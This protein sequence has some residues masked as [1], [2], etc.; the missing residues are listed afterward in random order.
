[1]VSNSEKN[2]EQAKRKLVEGFA[3]GM[4]HDLNNI[5]SAI[6]GYT[7]LCLLSEDI[8]HSIRSNLQHLREA[9]RTA[10]EFSNLIRIIG[11]RGIGARCIHTDIC[12]LLRESLQLIKKEL[13]PNVDM[14]ILVPDMLDE[15]QIEPSLLD[16]LLKHLCQ[17]AVQAMDGHGGVLR[18]VYEKM[19]P[20][21]ENRLES[22]NS[23]QPYLKLSIS[24]TGVGIPAEVLPHI[25]DPYFSTRSK[26]EGKGL[27]LA[28]VKG[29][30][31]GCGAEIFVDSEPGKGSCFSLCFSC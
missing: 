16:L 24:D 20:G 3:A 12:P 11:G 25:Y 19:L 15:V 22:I 8:P 29:I 6:V 26:G 7:D 21:S 2:T 23:Q 4:T 1:M 28:I 27:G 10:R 9:T 30:V 31:S 17:N 18:V 13:P 14:Q 5:L